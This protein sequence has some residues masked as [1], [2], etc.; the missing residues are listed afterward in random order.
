MYQP[1]LNLISMCIVV[2]RFNGHLDNIQF[3]IVTF[4]LFK[5]SLFPE[6]NCVH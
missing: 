6:K 4:T 5:T 1:D 2:F 3:S